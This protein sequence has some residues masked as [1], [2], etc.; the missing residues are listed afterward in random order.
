[1]TTPE[2]L[3]TTVRAEIAEAERPDRP[4]RRLL[5]RARAWIDAH[6]RL[7]R[8]YRACVG[9]VGGVL[10][11]G[12]LLLVPLPGPGWLVVFLGL[13]VLGTEFRW[14][15]RVA[16]WLKRMLDRFWTWW[17]ARRA[18]RSANAERA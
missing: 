1:M 17:R 7:N 16:D 5:G 11:V 14:A 15:R 12:G 10:A 4:I 13:A 3:E 2:T 8:V 9:T 6:P 18:A